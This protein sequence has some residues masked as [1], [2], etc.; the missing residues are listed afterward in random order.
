[1]G[2]TAVIVACLSHLTLSH[3]DNSLVNSAT[4]KFFFA[5]SHENIDEKRGV[6]SYHHDSEL[7]PFGNL[8]DNPPVQYRS[9]QLTIEQFINKLKEIQKGKQKLGLSRNKSEPE[10]RI[11]KEKKPSL[12]S[13]QKVTKSKESKVSV[14]AKTGKLNEKKISSVLGKSK[15]KPTHQKKGVTKGVGDI[16]RQKQSNKSI[17]NQTKKRKPSSGLKKQ[18]S[19]KSSPQTQKQKK[20]HKPKFGAEIGKDIKEQVEEDFFQSGPQGTKLS[21]IH[22]HDHLHAHKAFHK[23][24]ESHDHTH[25]HSNDHVH[26][27]KVRLTVQYLK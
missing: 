10:T 25:A 3:S 9:A 23:H 11:T 1:M 4:R 22:Q 2:W 21:H 20:F 26:N 7:L 17:L 24:K 14:S 27:H 18:E 19:D 5:D 12:S 8:E 16:K 13:G 15:T 6:A